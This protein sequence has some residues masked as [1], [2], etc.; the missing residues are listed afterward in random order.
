MPTKEIKVANSEIP[1]ENRFVWL[2]SSKKLNL[3]AKITM[4]ENIIP[5]KTPYRSRFQ[6]LHHS[7]MSS[8]V[9][10]NNAFHG[11]VTKIF[12]NKTWAVK[13]VWKLWFDGLYLVDYNGGLPTSDMY[14]VVTIPKKNTNLKTRYIYWMGWFSDVRPVILGGTTKNR[15]INTNQKEISGRNSYDW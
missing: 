8:S 2:V 3:W 7:V 10:T 6:L 12:S 14:N 1:L 15:V 13:E 5:H 11:R 4:A 9:V